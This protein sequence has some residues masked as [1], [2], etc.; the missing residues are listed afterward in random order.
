MNL[1]NKIKKYLGFTVSEP[2]ID[3]NDVEK[4]FLR[5]Y[6]NN[7]EYYLFKVERKDLDNDGL[8]RCM[9]IFKAE[10]NHILQSEND[11]NYNYFDYDHVYIYFK[12]KEGNRIITQSEIKVLFD[13]CKD[14]FYKHFNTI[15]TYKHIPL[16]DQFNKS[17]TLKTWF[18]FDDLLDFKGNYKIVRRE[19]LPDLIHVLTKILNDKG[20][21]ANDNK[22][23]PLYYGGITITANVH[24]V[25]IS[26]LVIPDYK[27]G[28]NYD[29]KD[30][31]KM[32][33]NIL[34][35][36]VCDDY[37]IPVV[38]RKEPIDEDINLEQMPE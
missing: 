29:I 22:S 14:F 26:G 1:I 9:K 7:P 17:E 18:E 28:F 23:E 34:N 10:L 36:H 27:Y 24:Q 37:F 8:Y 3:L 32:F 15:I 5:N 35:R 19:K 33:E 12:V 13:R 6:E 11:V 16:I 20:F 25:M 4:A 21:Y 38:K 31:R 2:D 30:F